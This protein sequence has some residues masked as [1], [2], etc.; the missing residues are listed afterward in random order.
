MSR[1]GNVVSVV[2]SPEPLA[3]IRGVYA[4]LS[5]TEKRLATHVLHHAGEVIHTPIGALAAR[6]GV[7]EASVVRFCQRLGYKGYPDFRIFLARDLG[8]PFEDAYQGIAEA[9]DA[10]SVAR[11]VFEL[12]I[13]ALSDALAALDKQA[14]ARASEAL[15]SARMIYFFGVGGSGEAT[16]IAHQ[17]LLRAAIPCQVCTDA[18]LQAL[19]AATAQAGD[20]AVG[21]SYSGG[22][23]A[24]TR[25]LMIAR[26][27]GA[28]TIGLVSV[29]RSPVAQAAD[30]VL[31]TGGADPRVSEPQTSRLV[32]IAVLDALC[33]SVATQRQSNGAI[34]DLATGE[35]LA[36]R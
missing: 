6:C 19:V 14:F 28:T 16:R 21:V 15:A 3:R 23:D 10:A 33:A 26:Q 1:N 7:S 25:A 35:H 20:A 12:S 22:S 31:L 24:V 17:R 34:S 9:K 13:R 2:G 8:H 30:I 32:Q 27:R 5:A 29:A 4:S 18:H 36:R 11:Q